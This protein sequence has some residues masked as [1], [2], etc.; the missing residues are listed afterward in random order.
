MCERE[1]GEGEVTAKALGRG[2]TGT[3]V[4]DGDGARDEG[5][6]ATPGGGDTHGAWLR[7]APRTSRP[8][9]GP[10]GHDVWVLR[11]YQIEMRSVLS[12]DGIIICLK[13]LGTR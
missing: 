11:I 4:G 12:A 3:G 6:A 7:R 13:A 8:A 5:K 10:H 9:A 2:G 1:R